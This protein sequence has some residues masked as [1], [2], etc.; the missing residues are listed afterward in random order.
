MMPMRLANFFSDAQLVGG[1]ECCHPRLGPFLEN[2]FH[3]AGV[4]RVQTH[5][6]LVNHEDIRLVQ[7]GGDDGSADA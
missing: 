6:G 1:Y 2:V 3:H 5:H 7:Q 4:L